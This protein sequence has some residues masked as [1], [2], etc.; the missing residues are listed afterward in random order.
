MSKI[1]PVVVTP[2]RPQPQ[3]Q[4]PVTNEEGLLDQLNN[5]ANQFRQF[6]SD[7]YDRSLNAT[8]EAISDF[9]DNITELL[10]PDYSSAPI[11]NEPE[12]QKNTPNTPPKPETPKKILHYL[13]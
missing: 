12:P 4:P 1:S 2:P 10:T 7:A 13:T 8:G 6:L 9:G 5:S 3:P 11:Y